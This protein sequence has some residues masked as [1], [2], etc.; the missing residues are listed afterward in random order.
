MAEVHGRSQ[1]VGRLKTALGWRMYEMKSGR[2]HV[3]RSSVRGT[4]RLMISCARGGTRWT[5]SKGRGK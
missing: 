3:T 1:E 4:T 2:N 5:N